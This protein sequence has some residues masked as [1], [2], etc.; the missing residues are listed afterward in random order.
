MMTTSSQA[1]G[2]GELPRWT[3][4][5][6]MATADGTGPTLNLA[7]VAAGICVSGSVQA[8]G[9]AMPAGQQPVDLWARGPDLTAVYEPSDDRRLR[10][11]AMWRLGDAGSEH[12]IRSSE[13]VLS[14]QTSLLSSDAELTVLATASGASALAAGEWTAEG[15]AWQ[16][17]PSDT[18][19][20]L[21]LTLAGAAQA[22]ACLQLAIHPDDA[23]VIEVDRDSAGTCRIRCRLFPS[24][25]EK[26]V[27]LRSR[28][29]MAVWPN[30]TA[31]GGTES[32]TAE[33]LQAFAGSEPILAT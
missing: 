5:S 22:A 15:L 6:L 4:S 26:G 10:V 28:V 16:S 2:S 31:S 13:L 20:C 19:R 27:L 17:A 12:G 24:N 3:L 21:R 33:L 29:L 25:V 18:T 32:W 11:T 23:G 7:D 14:A 30:D 8:L 1:I 9:L